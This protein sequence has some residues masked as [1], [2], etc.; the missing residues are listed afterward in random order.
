MGGA[1]AAL[2]LL[3]VGRL[4]SVGAGPWRRA[5]RAPWFAVYLLCA[6]LAAAAGYVLSRPVDAVVVRYFLLTLLIPIGLSAIWLSVE[7]RRTVRGIVAAA[8]VAWAA[9]S[10][11]DHVRYA[12]RFM[13]GEVPNE[14]RGVADALVAGG[15]P[16][17]RAGYWVAYEVTFLSGERVRVASTDFVR[18]SEYQRLADRSPAPVPRLTDRPCPGGRPVAAWY[19]CDP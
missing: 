17:A 14:L 18:I 15:V 8:L 12:S 4:S 13:A 3:A 9:A 5:D 7:P 10:S 11:I 19:L 16:V 2:G 1:T 6:G